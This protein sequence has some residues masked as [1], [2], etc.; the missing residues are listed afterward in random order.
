[1][2]GHSIT[3]GHCACALAL[4]LAAATLLAA[5]GRAQTNATASSAPRA[6]AA[7][8]SRPSGVA[9]FEGEPAAAFDLAREQRK[10]VFVYFGAVWCPPCQ[11]LKATIFRR[12]DFLDRLTL[13]VPV[14]LDGDAPDA[15]RW[16]DRFHVIGYPTVLN[17]RSDRSEIERV[18]GG[19]DLGRYAEV[20]GAGIGAVRPIED[21]LASVKGNSASL[22]DDECRILAYNGWELD[23]AWIFSD[24]QPQA[25]AQL[26]DLIARGAERCPPAAK[27]ERARLELTAAAAAVKLDA[28]DLKAGKPP[29]P[30][31]AALVQ[32][33]LPLLADPVAHE[34]G[35][36]LLELPEG[37][38][39]AAARLD[40]AHTA[41]LENRYVGLMDEFASD[42]RYS[43]PSQL[44][45]L[46]KKLAVVQAL[47]PSGKAPQ[48]MADQA[49]QRAELVLT[50]VH[51]PYARTAAVN[52]VL[53]LLEQLGD[54]ERSYA[55]LAGEVK[56]SAT[57][58]YY[59]SELGALEEKRGHKEAAIDWFA[60]SYLDSQ[61][62]ATR[63]QW[64]SR[65]VLALIR[66]RPDDETAIRNTTLQLLRELE[67][68]DSI[69]GRNRRALDSLFAHLHEWGNGG[70]HAGALG[71][72]RTSM[73]Q[74]CRRVSRADT[75]P[76]SCAQLVAKI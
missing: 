44:W 61:G 74:V 11:E 40:P 15:Q 51:E 38:F 57:P 9:W 29:S 56:T 12:K 17:L 14:Y 53:N 76:G 36:T 19:M 58:Y 37:F 39:V 69:H 75:V 30:R 27:V 24:E 62:Q 6:L 68:G 46:T 4:L 72:I 65:Y 43:T 64:G 49:L 18:S 8:P 25:L 3:P 20:L 2:S 71:E 33:T 59:M 28:A 52:E 7:H 5:C 73:D 55:V 54:E 26:S 22:S 63:T 34:F 66:L 10:P 70:V 32:R 1:M 60:R 16:A 45:A 67:D 23:D 47:E 50:Q 13:Y 48:V 35:E 21:I 31:L 42:S 41:D